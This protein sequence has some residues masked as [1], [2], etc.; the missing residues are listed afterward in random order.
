MRHYVRFT[1]EDGSPVLVELAENDMP[2]E[3]GGI[4]GAGPGQKA[5]KLVTTAAEALE[6]ALAGAL[7][8]N[9]RAFM[10]AL[11]GV[12][13]PPREAQITFGFKWAGE[14]GF[15]VAKTTSEATYSITLTWDMSVPKPS[16][17]GTAGG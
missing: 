11:E 7:R 16:E 8:R 1:T 6:T 17:E 4:Q 15:T 5:K 12:E 14:L 9:T 10:K 2:D 13:P 3:E